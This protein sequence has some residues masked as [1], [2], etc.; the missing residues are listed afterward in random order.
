MQF[1]FLYSP[2]SIFPNE[3][4]YAAKRYIHV[5]QEGEEDIFFVLAEAVIPAVRAG[6][7]GL[8]TFDQTNCADGAEAN[9]AP[10]LLLG[11]T[12]NVRLE[13]MVE[14]LRQGIDINDDNDPE[15]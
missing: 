3:Q 7:I 6:A 4:F 5:T 10:I 15:P 2:I 9:D 8:L 11:R 14:L 13:D 1:W 12:S